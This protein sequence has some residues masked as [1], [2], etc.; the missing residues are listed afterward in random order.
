MC[1]D[2]RACIHDGGTNQDQ[3]HI[4]RIVSIVLRRMVRGS[5]ATRSHT[6]Y[7]FMVPAVPRLELVNG[8]LCLP[9]EVYIGLA[10]RRP[11]YRSYMSAFNLNDRH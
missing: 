5:S 8:T 10:G 4:A 11:P 7:V 6:G 3:D 1:W 2:R 9:D